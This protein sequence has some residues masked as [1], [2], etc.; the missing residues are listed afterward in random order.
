[1]IEIISLNVAVASVPSSKPIPAATVENFTALNRYSRY[2]SRGFLS[3]TQAV[4]VATK[5]T[6][7]NTTQKLIQF[8]S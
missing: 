2:F 6:I 1:M 7:S 5:A 4:S 3:L 8:W